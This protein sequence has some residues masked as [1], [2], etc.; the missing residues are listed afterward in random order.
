LIWNVR[1]LNSSARQD[2]VRTLVD[3]YHVDIVCLQELKMATVP[4]RVLLTMLG[5][6]FSGH[7]ELPENGTSG[8]VLVAWRR[9]LGTIGQHRIDSFSVSVQLCPDGGQAW[10]ATWVY[11]PQGN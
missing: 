5:T 11:G 10:W 7:I 8:G 6:D 1:G 2:A 9:A 3:S 4:Q